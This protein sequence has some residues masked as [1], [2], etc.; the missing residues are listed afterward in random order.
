MKRFWNFSGQMIVGWLFVAVAQNAPVVEVPKTVNDY[1]QS[2]LQSYV[3]G[4]FDQAILWDSKAL[5]VDPQD[6]KAQDLL[7]ILVSEKDT[8]NKTVIWIGGKPTVVENAPSN[9]ISQVPVTVF[10][11]KSTRPVATDSR[12][13][14]ELETR[15]QTVAFLMER[16]SFNQYRELS[17]A[18]AE[19]AKRLDQISFDLKGLG[20]GMRFSNI[21]FILALIVAGIALWKSWKNGEEIKRQAEAFQQSAPSEERGRVIKIHRM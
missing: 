13:V 14:Q 11:E 5:Q 20:S 2:A 18:Q 10:K 19:T 12:K 6:K 4:D 21:L 15:V 16:D 1:Y 3:A 17:G 7:S 8:A 9:N